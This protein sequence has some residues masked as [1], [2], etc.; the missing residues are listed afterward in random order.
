MKTT[1]GQKITQHYLGL[2]LYK[3]IPVDRKTEKKIKIKT[4]LK[5]NGRD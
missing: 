3:C 4:G 2:K 5:Q 1:S